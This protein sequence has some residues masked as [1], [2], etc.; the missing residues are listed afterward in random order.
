M[1]LSGQHRIDAP[2]LR[3]WQGLN[4]AAILARITPGCESLSRLE[5]GFVATVRQPI[6]PLVARFEGRGRIVERLPPERLALRG[7]GDAG[8]AGLIDGEVEI[9]LEESDPQTTL[10]RYHATAVLQGQLAALDSWLIEQTAETFAQEICTRF[11]REMSE[12]PALLPR[13]SPPEEGLAP[14][15]WVSGFV[16][17]TLALVMA[18]AMM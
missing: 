2:R 9:T 17:V 8:P 12:P 13:H 15:V 11:A 4:D 6:G 7:R 14:V 18:C 16:A 1:N 10:L 3:V 5:D